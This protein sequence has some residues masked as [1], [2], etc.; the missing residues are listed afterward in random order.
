MSVDTVEEISS[1]I[2]TLKAQIK[3]AGERKPAPAQHADRI[4]Q[5]RQGG[6]VR[7]QA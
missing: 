6:G 3:E 4:R 7:L 5:D 1:P 2:A